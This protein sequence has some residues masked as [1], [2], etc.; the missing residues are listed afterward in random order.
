[1]ALNSI[2]V[3][4]RRALFST[5]IL[6]AFGF[7]A[8]DA[9]GQRPNIVLFLVDDMGW[10]DSSVPFDTVSSVWNSIYRTPNMER[11]ASK[12]V[13][14]TQAYASAVS[15]PSRVSL[16][17]GIDPA[18]H[19]VTN[20]TL[21]RNQSEDLESDSIEM[22]FWNMNGLQPKGAEIEN[23]IEATTLADI[24][25][26]RGYSTILCGKAHFGAMESP[27]ADPINLGF[28][29]NIAGHAA[30][31]LASYL[32]EQNFGNSAD[33]TKNPF[34]V[35][36]LDRY[37]GEDIFVTQALT[38]E[39]LRAVDSVRRASRGK[40]FFLYM[41][42][43][44]VHIP[45]DKDERYYDSYIA[46]GLSDNAA[47][48]AALIEGMDSSLGDIL[49]YLDSADIARNTV[50]VFLSDNGGL[51]ACG[52]DGVA[53]NYNSPLRGGK[54]S[55]LEGGIRVPMIVFDPK[56]RRTSGV[57][58]RVVNIT[59]IF[60]SLL[61][62]AGANIRSAGHRVDGVSWL[63]MLRGKSVVGER[64]L[65]WHYPNKWGCDGDG[66]GTYSAI[67]SGDYKFIYY[68]DTE[69]GMLF[70]IAN[71]LSESNNLAHNA[72]Y[73]DVRARLASELTQYLKS[74]GAQLPYRKSDGE[75]CHYPK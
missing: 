4:Y 56:I 1:M 53:D 62:I 33:G 52:R 15:S 42:H 9:F 68:Y 5:V 24:L 38:I 66:I 58:S 37:W 8:G 40:P 29:V 18:S 41:S 14:F 25:K 61:E 65:V 36:G 30:G 45:F 11:L 21:R 44:A 3:M 17:T 16:M 57:E 12:G 55:A 7:G 10:Q 31:G 47:R 23:S 43:Y 67:R 6:G 48:Y 34:A 32:G 22:P 49:N 75:V 72:A 64:T 51:S 54:G 20:W 19:G 73:A 69:V 60:P 70:N 27:G 74:R 13:K 35:P 2:D 71:D 59:D 39:A 28:D 50:V 26:K 46:A 63:S